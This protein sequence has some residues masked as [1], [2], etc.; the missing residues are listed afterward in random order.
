MG[1]ISGMGWWMMQQVLHAHSILLHMV[2]AARAARRK[3]V[4]K[5]E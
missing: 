4:I 1:V 3:E 5:S 2:D